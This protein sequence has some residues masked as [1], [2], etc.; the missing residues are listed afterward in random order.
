MSISCHHLLHS[1]DASKIA[2]AHYVS[3][4]VYSSAPDAV[5]YYAAWSPYDSIKLDIQT[6]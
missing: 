5:M 1:L 4:Q 3:A 6:P 2:H